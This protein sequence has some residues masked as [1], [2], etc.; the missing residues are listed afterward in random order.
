MR[1]QKRTAMNMPRPRVFPSLC[2]WLDDEVSP[3]WLADFLA[4]INLTPHLD[5]LL[6]TKRPEN[7]MDRIDTAALASTEFH[8]KWLV[9]WLKGTP[10]P[11]VWFGVSV[12]DQTRADERIPMILD[13]PAQLRW[14]SVEPL[15]GPVKL[16]T[17]ENALTW[18]DGPQGIQWLVIGGESGHGARPCNIEWI[19]RLVGEGMDAGIPVFVKQLGKW[20]ID[21]SS[22][23]G[24]IPLAPCHTLNLKHPKGGDPSEWPDDLRVRQFPGGEK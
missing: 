20:A 22:P 17:I 18:Y 8:Q 16:E 24:S 7:W 19:R 12:E 11:N 15:I 9:E 21:P 1:W 6:L 2:D 5:W 14:L 3:A 23:N 4:L 10:P 13:I